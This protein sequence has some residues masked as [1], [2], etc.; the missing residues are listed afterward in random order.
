MNEEFRDKV[1]SEETAYSDTYLTGL[2]LSHYNFMLNDYSYFQFSW[3][4]EAHVRYAYYPNPYAG[5]AGGLETFRR[6]RELLDAGMINL[7]EYLAL[8][9]DDPPEARAPLIRYENAPDQYKALKHPC[10]HFHIGN[11]GDD[12]WAL[13]RILTPRAFTLLVLKLY[14]GPIWRERG[15]DE[16]NE[17]GNTLEGALIAEKTDCRPVA[18][19]MFTNI[20]RRSFFFS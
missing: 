11:H 17:F 20:E 16:T 3:D 9:W 15:Q 1:L 6:R 5:G 8:F 13:N 14:Y 12:R 7:E 4:R 10:S 19:T 2:R 18:D